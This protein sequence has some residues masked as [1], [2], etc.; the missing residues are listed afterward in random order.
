MP[1]VRIEA[2]EAAVRARSGASERRPSLGVAHVA[3]VLLAVA[4]CGSGADNA[5]DADNATDAG[6]V[7]ARPGP[8]TYFVVAEWPGEARHG[9]SYVLPVTRP[10]DIEHARALIELGP[11]VAGRAVAVANIRL[12]PDGINRDLR[13]PGQPA[14]SWHVT[15]L[16]GFSD[17]AVE[18]L[19][20]WPGWIEQDPEGW[21][22][23]TP[24]SDRMPD[25]EGSVG[26]W[27][28]TVVEELAGAPGAAD[29]TPGAT[30][31]ARA[32]HE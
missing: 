13:A 10:E 1:N 3:G 18:I 7:D 28:Y 9:D 8:V 27:G 15:E 11:Q 25:D 6:A 17:C 29:M 16:L 26:F 21:M 23:N 24:P 19:D 12:G 30:A 22:Q 20:G 2:L 31:R 4:S 32:R 5:A 14:W